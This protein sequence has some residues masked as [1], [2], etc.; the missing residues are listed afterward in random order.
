VLINQNPLLYNKGRKNAKEEDVKQMRLKAA[1]INLTKD[2]K[3]FLNDRQIRLA[4]SCTL[5]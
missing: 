2:R 1:E 5:R 4:V 3:K